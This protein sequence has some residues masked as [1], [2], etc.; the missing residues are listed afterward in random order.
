MLALPAVLLAQGPAPRAQATTDGIDEIVVVGTDGYVY[1]YDYQG[2]QVFKSPENGWQLVTTG[3]LNGDGDQEIIAV[4]GNRIKAYDPQIVGDEYTYDVTYTGSGGSFKKV[5][6]GYL[7]GDDDRLDI[8]LIRSVAGTESRIVIYKTTS[9]SPAKDVRFLYSNWD[10][11]AI[12]DYDGDGDDDFALTYWNDSYPAGMKSWLEM[13]KGHDPSQRLEGSSTNGLYSDLVWFDI[14]AGDFVTTNGS[15]VELVG[16][17]NVNNIRVLKW[18]NKKL[19][20]VWSVGPAFE[21]VAAADFRGEGDAQVAMLRNVSSGVSLQFARSGNSNVKP[22]ASISGLG[23]GWLNLAAGNLDTEKVKKEAVIIKSNLIRVYLQPQNGQ[24]GEDT[25]LD[26][27]TVGNCFENFDLSGQLNG[28]L[29]VG[30]L[31]INFKTVTPYEVTPTLL[32]HTVSQSSTVPSDTLYIYGEQSIGVPLHWG[33]VALSDVS[34]RQLQ[35]LTR[36]HPDLTL[37]LTP[38]G[39]SYRGGGGTGQLPI[40]NWVQLSA[41]T[42]TTPSTLTVTYSGTYA[43]SLLFEAGAHK[44]TI[45]VWQTDLPSDRFRYADVVVLVAARMLYLPVILK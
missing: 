22:W 15:K 16:S 43:G 44:A 3:D 17:Q 30:D 20:D 26:C 37:S 35:Q 21:F 11:F 12:A 10:N 42:G 31:G 39:L 29:A 33:A 7:V 34:A 28:E 14:A 27:N 24:N 38:D 41:Y 19:K 1:A 8:A 45:L 23:T 9:T 32:A 25:Y 4:G 5:G 13:W 2:K 6:V 40:A 18:G 36:Q